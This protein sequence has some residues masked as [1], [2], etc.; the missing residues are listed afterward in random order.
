MKCLETRALG[1]KLGKN[2]I[3]TG[4]DICIRPGLTV[5]LGRNGCG[6]STLLRAL[7]GLI[8]SKGDILFN[9]MSIKKIGVHERAKLFSYLPQ[10]QTAPSGT[11]VIDYVAMPAGG[12]F[13][14]QHPEHIRQAAEE[15]EKLGLGSIAYR[16]TDTLSGG[17]LRLIGLARCR[18]Q[19]SRLMLMDEP[20]AGLDFARQH[21]FMQ[22]ALDSDR[23]ILMSAHDPMIAWQYAY[24]ILLMH[25]G[26]VSR[27]ERGDE[28][29]FEMLLKEIYGAEMRF[30][31]TGSFRLPIWHND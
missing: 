13:S 21:Q 22:Q 24:D 6:K 27:C 5:L 14:P 12:P 29:R 9:G 4:L 25:G 18:M 2:E 16:R 23:P 10:K 11:S 17:E 26:H 15:L 28:K 1:V 31:Q 7:L 30:E 19:K 8:P 20:L 3:F